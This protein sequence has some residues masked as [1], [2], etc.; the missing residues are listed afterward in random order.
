MCRILSPFDY[1][2]ADHG[3]PHPVG[4]AVGRRE[5]SIWVDGSFLT[6]KIDPKDVGEERVSE[7]ISTKGRYAGLC[8]R[9]HR[10]SEVR[11]PLY[12]G[13]PR[14]SSPIR[15]LCP[16]GSRQ[17]VVAAIGTGDVFSKGR[18]FAAWLG[19]VPP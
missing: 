13:K 9:W 3:W 18:D 1:A 14:G 16:H 12:P 4:S 7:A 11:R 6:D 8:V 2:P 15:R 5:D 17:P 10:R 19:L